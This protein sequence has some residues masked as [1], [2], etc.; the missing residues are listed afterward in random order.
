[1][2]HLQQEGAKFNPRLSECVLVH[3]D[4]Y[5]V[6]WPAEVFLWIFFYPID[7]IFVQSF[8]HIDEPYT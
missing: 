5:D 3:V 6:F 1:M 7:Y 4:L 8:S 2:V